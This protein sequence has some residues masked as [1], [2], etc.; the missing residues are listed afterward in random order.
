MN[1]PDYSY[2]G[3]NA[4]VM[5][6]EYGSAAPFLPVGNCSELNV[7]PQEDVIKLPDFT[8]PGGGVRNSVSRIND[9]QF[10]LKFHDMNADNMN[11]FLRG[12]ST[13]V[14]SGAV[15]A[16]QVVA[17]KGGLIPLEKIAKTITS[18]SPYPTGAT[19]TVGTDYQLDNGGLYIPSTST[20]PNATGGAPNIKVDYTYDAH[21]LTEAL[22]TTAKQYE[23]LFL[24]MNDARSGNPVRVW[25]YK[26]SAGVLSEM[27]LIATDY[28]GGTV[29]GSLLAD[30]TRGAGL[31]KYFSAVVVG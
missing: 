29:S 12:T 3:S 7:S 17:Y 24:G 8:G 1:E 28:F 31:S 11:R 21:T 16:E 4:H 5:V 9:V 14:T 19:Y 30:P 18:V 22:V 6:R 13:T 25:A 10:S 23:L 27:A 2:I 26:V 15:T 20:I